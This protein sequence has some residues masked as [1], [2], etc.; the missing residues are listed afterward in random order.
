MRILLLD[1]ETA[2]NVAHV[3]GL[4]KQNISISQLM[5]SSYVMCWSAKW[6]GEP[7]VTFSSIP[8]DGKKR[9]LNKVHKL[10]DKADAVVHYNGTRFDIPTLNKE[11]LLAG[12]YA[13]ATYKQI[14]LLKTARSCFKFPSNKLDYVA[15]ALNL[16]KKHKHT[17]HSL[18]VDCMAGN[19]DAW[20]LME[21]Y[22]KQD[23]VLLEKVYFSLLP[24]IKGH[25]NHNLYNNNEF[26]CPN[27]GSHTL[28]KRGF[29][30]SNT[31]KYQR[32]QCQ[33]CGTWSKDIKSTPT[34][35]KITQDKT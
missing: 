13:P 4:F 14:D 19:K 12:M 30:Y 3:W 28:Q 27:C 31:L 9:M 34:L 6:L 15:Q 21:E 16:G 7:E 33:S 26:A 22:N 20:K 17:G 11:F 25:P 23:V 5:D 1:I 8:Q 24:W 10:L 29:T 32:Y 18:W 35:N 2:P